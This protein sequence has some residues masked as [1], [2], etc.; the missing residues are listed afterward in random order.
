MVTLRLNP[1]SSWKQAVVIGLVF[2]FITACSNPQRDSLMFGSSQYSAGF[3]Y[4]SDSVIGSPGSGS[5]MEH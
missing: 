4:S 2:L 3:G 5:I 1:S